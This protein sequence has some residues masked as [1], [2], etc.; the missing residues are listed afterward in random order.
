MEDYITL[1][2]I[3]IYNPKLFKTKNLKSFVRNH[4]IQEN[5]M[6][7]LKANKIGIKKNWLKK[8]LP[9]FNLKLLEYSDSND[10][11]FFE[12]QSTLEKY[13][14]KIF[15][16][17]ALNLDSTTVQ[18]FNK[19]GKRTPY[20]TR[21]G[22]IKIMVLF[23]DVPEN[24]FNWTYELTN[25]SMQSQINNL[26]NVLEMV[27]LN[28]VPVVKNINGKMVLSNHIY[29][30]DKGDVV[31]DFKRIGDLKK[32]SDLTCSIDGYKCPLFSQIQ[33]NFQKGLDEAEQNF[34]LKVKELIQEK[35]ILHLQQELEKEKCLKDQAISLTQSFI[36][37]FITETPFG[38]SAS[39]GPLGPIGNGEIK[40]SPSPYIASSGTGKLKPS[41]IQ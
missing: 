18:Y 27:N 34:N 13:G 1:S 31:V 14:C 4:K 26:S 28:H 23:N 24:I 22:L 9:S 17:I 32:E 2:E 40:P 20:F 16:P 38:R 37:G 10:S 36:P 8:N 35:V 12:V 30:I 6:V 41:K 33:T 19:D 29:T 39:I 7:K 5:D 25:G 21:K 15:N 11:D 3:Y